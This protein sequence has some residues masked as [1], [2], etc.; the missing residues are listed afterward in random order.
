VKVSSLGISCAEYFMR[1]EPVGL[2]DGGDTSYT[3]FVGQIV[4]FMGFGL[5]SFSKIDM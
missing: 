5:W 1:S 4:Q 3:E 2:D